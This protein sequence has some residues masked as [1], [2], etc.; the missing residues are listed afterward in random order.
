MH[1]LHHQT[2]FNCDILYII[3][4]INAIVL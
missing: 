3:T 2:K 1:V 4:I